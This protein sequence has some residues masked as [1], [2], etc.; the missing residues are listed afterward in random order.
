MTFEAGAVTALIGPNGAG[1]T[2]L[3]HLMSGA[4]RPDSGQVLYGDVRVDG[5]PSW[6]VAGMGIGRLFQDVRVFKRL[7]VLSTLR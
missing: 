5:L 7:T 1:K 4:L 2:T 6:R 3:F